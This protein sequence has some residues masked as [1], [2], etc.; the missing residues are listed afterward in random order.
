[1]KEP[2]QPPKSHPASEF[3]NGLGGEIPRPRRDATGPFGQARFG[4]FISIRNGGFG[5]FFEID[6]ELN[7]HTS[8]FRPTGVRQRPSISDEI[9]SRGHDILSN[10]PFDVVDGSSPQASKFQFNKFPRLQTG[11]DLTF[12]CKPWSRSGV[13]GRCAVARQTLDFLRQ[14]IFEGRPVHRLVFCR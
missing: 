2:Q 12:L 14:G 9:A 11:R 10:A 4:G 13:R 1:M 6:Y 5:S 7:G 8:V 3:V